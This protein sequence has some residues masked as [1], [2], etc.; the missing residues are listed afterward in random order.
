M[1]WRSDARR[2]GGGR[3]RTLERPYVSDRTWLRKTGDPRNM[4]EPQEDD[5]VTEVTPEPR[6]I[7]V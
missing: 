3:T 7:D 4:L 6:R 5:H 2:T 1:P